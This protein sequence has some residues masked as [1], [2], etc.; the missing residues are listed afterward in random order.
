MHYHK[1]GITFKGQKSSCSHNSNNVPLAYLAYQTDRNITASKGTIRT[2]N[3]IRTFGMDKYDTCTAPEKVFFS[4]KQIKQNCL[5]QTI[6]ALFP[7]SY[8]SATSYHTVTTIT[9]IS[10]W[11]NINY[12][13]RKI[14]EKI[15]NNFV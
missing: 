6:Q 4:T 1:K 2:F 12:K 9:S 5:T 10:F 11:S 14:R 15:I 3:D 7:L 13:T 8:I